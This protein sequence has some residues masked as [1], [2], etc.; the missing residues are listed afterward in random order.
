MTASR[1]WFEKDFYALLGVRPDASAEDIK[2]AYKKLAREFHPDRNPSPEAENRFKDVSEAYDVLSRDESRREYDEIRQMARQGYV[3]GRPGA[4]FR[5]H[6]VQFEDLP[7]DLGDLLGGM[8]GGGRRAQREP[9]PPPPA[10]TRRTVRVPFHLATLGGQIRVPTPSGTVTMKI[11]PG[12]Q[13]GAELRLR[14]KGDENGNGTRRDVIVRIDVSVPT[15]LDAEE[16]ALIE[17]LRDLAAAR[18]RAAK[19]TT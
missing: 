16:R 15:E 17:G 9:S 1:D 13:P 7:I 2:K 6:G 8:F 10:E 12:T 3:G 5:S 14:G 4:G 19:E 11:A 18:R